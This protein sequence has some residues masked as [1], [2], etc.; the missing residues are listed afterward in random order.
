LAPPAV[1]AP[2]IYT[3]LAWATTLGFLIFG[4]VPD[5][6][7]LVGAAIV[8]ASGLYM[9]NRERKVGPRREPITAP[10]TEKRPPQV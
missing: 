9:L 5:R 7:T 2:F 6:W 1:L 10:R 4:D 8:V 3:Q